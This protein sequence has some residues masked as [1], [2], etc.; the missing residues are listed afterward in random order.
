[1]AL[2]NTDDECLYSGEKDSIDH[3]LLNCQF[4][5]IFVNNVIDWLITRSYL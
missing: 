2:I 3:T 4:V 1:M 5:K